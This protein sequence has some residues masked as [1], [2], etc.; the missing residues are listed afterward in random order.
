[1]LELAV[2]AA[3][4]RGASYGYQL[5]SRLAEAGL[6]QVKGGTLYP[7]LGRLERDGL[8]SSHWGPGDGGPGRKHYGLTDLGRDRLVR[9]TQDW[10]SFASRIA[11]ITEGIED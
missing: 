4:A 3:M 2:L 9:L 7:L 5:S 8:V 1:V 11:D 10:R 6:G